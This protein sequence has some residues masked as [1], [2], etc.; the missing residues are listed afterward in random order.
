VRDG[1]VNESLLT[2]L[3]ARL[4]AVRGLEFRHPVTVRAMGP[5]EIA[6]TI[7]EEIAHDLPPADLARLEGV[8]T[9]LHLIP[10][11]S[12]LGSSMRRLLTTQLAAFYDPRSKIL[13]V[14][15]EAVRAEEG[16]GLRILGAVSGRDPVGELVLAHELTHALQDQHWGIPSEAEAATESHGDRILA[17]R[18]LLEGDATWA[19]F[20]C[21]AGATPD[22]KTRARVL[23]Q[24][25]LLSQKLNAAYPD[26]PELLR[27]ALVFQYEAG[28]A[29]VDRLLAHGGWAAV[30]RAQADPPQSSEQVLHPERYLNARDTPVD[31]QLSPTLLARDGFTLV[32]ADTLGE[33]GVRTLARRFLPPQDAE[34]IAAGWDGDRLAAF[35]RGQD[36]VIVWLTAWDSEADASEFAG[37]F[38]VIQPEATVQRRGAR[39]FVML[40]PAPPGLPDRIWHQ[41]V[42]RA[43]R[44]QS[45]PIEPRLHGSFG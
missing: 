3:E 7:D 28:A 9:T 45:S 6:A 37:A 14:S 25:R 8:Y 19:S 33:V 21:V 32:M 36:T 42:S 22:A 40:G 38:A 10:P 30:D 41:P 39:V 15:T 11:G 29:F 43:K 23:S 20:A 2:A 34:R 44:A 13:A 1:Q 27:D 26:A 24:L 12:A 31:V 35:A 4:S 18:A 16:V 5:A 17:R